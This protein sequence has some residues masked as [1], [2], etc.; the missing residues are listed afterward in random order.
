VSLPHSPVMARSCVLSFVPGG[1]SR[2]TS[3]ADGNSREHECEFTLTAD[4]VAA[5]PCRVCE[6]RTRQV[7]VR[8]D[9]WVLMLGEALPQAWLT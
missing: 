5:I 9:F 6:G 4:H 8:V 2:M 3:R 1:P 7:A